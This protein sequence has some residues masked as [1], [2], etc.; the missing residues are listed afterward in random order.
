ME[1]KKKYQSDAEFFGAM[2]AMFAKKL[3][4]ELMPQ[5]KLTKEEKIALLKKIEEEAIKKG[6][7]Q[8]MQQMG[9]GLSNDSDYAVNI[10][11]KIEEQANK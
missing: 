5:P 4:G 8:T 1:E 3:K 7:S 9:V 6:H 11:S 2:D 10:I